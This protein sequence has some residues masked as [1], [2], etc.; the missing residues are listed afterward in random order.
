MA[1]EKKEPSAKE[2]AAETLA[3]AE[4]E[5]AF[6][7]ADIPP[8]MADEAI[9]VARWNHIVRALKVLAALEAVG[10]EAI[11]YAVR[12]LEGWAVPTE[13]SDAGKKALREVLALL[14]ASLTTPGED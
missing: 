1:N 13:D 5:R 2:D 8:A 6:Y 3:W 9:Y 7:D 14:G 4:K 11:R 10:P 12:G